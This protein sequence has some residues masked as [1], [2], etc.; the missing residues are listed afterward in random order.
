[1]IQ[2]GLARLFLALP[3]RWFDWRSSPGRPARRRL[4]YERLLRIRSW[5]GRLPDGGAWFG[6]GFAKRTLAGT[7]PDY[8]RRFVMETRRGEICHGTAIA[9]APLFL[10]WNPWW[11][12]AI[13]LAYAL[14][15]NLPCLL[16]QRYTRSRLERLSRHSPQRGSAS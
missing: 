8:L 11:G 3:L 4:A 14:L 10:L 13:N 2:L 1:M 9:C 6:G 16:A 7:D 12:F 5:K 15:A